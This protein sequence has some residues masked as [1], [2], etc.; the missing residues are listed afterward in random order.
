[1]AIQIRRRWIKGMSQCT[2]TVTRNNIH[3]AR[4]ALSSFTRCNDVVAWLQCRHWSRGVRCW[5]RSKHYHDI[6][7]SSCTLQRSCV[8]LRPRRFWSRQKWLSSVFQKRTPEPYTEAESPANSWLQLLYL[9][10]GVQ[11]LQQT[12]SKYVDRLHTQQY[13]GKTV[14]CLKHLL[15]I[16]LGY[17]LLQRYSNYIKLD[18][19]QSLI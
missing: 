18:A 9:S 13:H 8:R 10:D 6:H 17:V 14:V 16:F 3:G 12:W 4:V 2:W 19:R 1:M 7:C 11:A 5:F 15:S